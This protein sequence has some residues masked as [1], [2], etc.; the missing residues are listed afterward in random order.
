MIFNDYIQMLLKFH[1]CPQ[2]KKKKGTS[3]EEKEKRI[4]KVSGVLWG[5]GC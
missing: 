2:I 3:C 1:W 5:Q 4:S